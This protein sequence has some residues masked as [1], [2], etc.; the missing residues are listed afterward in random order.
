MAAQTYGVLE[1]V[2]PEASA[3][4]WDLWC[5]EL[6]ASGSEWL[7]A[8]PPDAAP[9]WARA[10]PPA[11]VPEQ[12]DRVPPDS[13]PGGSASSVRVRHFF[14]R[15]PAGDVQAWLDGFRARFPDVPGPARVSWSLRPVEAWDTEWR[16]HFSALAV[17]ERLLICPP[18]QE[19]GADAGGSDDAAGRAGRLRIVIEPGQG[20]G[21][22]RHA[23]TA[24]ALT[25]LERALGWATRDG[26]ARGGAASGGDALG[27][28]ARGRAPRRRFPERMLDVGTG[29]GI[30][31]IA[32]RLL[33]VREGWALDVDARV[34][35]E[36]RRNLA[37]SGLGDAARPGEAVRLVIGTP[38]A[39]RGDFPLVVANIS[40]PVLTSLAADLRRLTSPGGDLILSGMLVPEVEPVL[41]AGFGAG[42]ARVSRAEADGWAAVWLT[43]R[44]SG[45]SAAPPAAPSAAIQDRP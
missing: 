43:R 14:T 44:A 19:E 16:R 4:L 10:E 40:A 35:A 33:G 17:G 9:A 5:T 41:Q 30:L 38:A 13:V 36:V 27:G 7:A 8:A 29:S 22:G 11:A 26:A 45:P 1:A 28:A 42:W 32:A 31:L 18:W 6:G 20:F 21:T 3:E 39:L 34:G 23:S 2:L 12:R 37:L 24:L 15:P 25:L